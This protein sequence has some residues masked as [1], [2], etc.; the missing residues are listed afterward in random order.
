MLHLLERVPTDESV[1]TASHGPSFAEVIQQ[2]QEQQQ[3]QDAPP[4]VE[5]RYIPKEFDQTRSN[6]HGVVYYTEGVAGRYPEAI[7]FTGKARK[8]AWYYSFSGKTGLERMHAH[9]DSYLKGLEAHFAE[10]EKY[11]AA[12]AAVVAS[13]FFKVG[14]IVSNSWGWE[15]TNVDW[16]QV[17]GVTKKFVD[18]R[19]IAGKLTEYT[20]AMA[21][22]SIPIPGKFTSE[23]ITRH[24]IYPSGDSC[25]VNFKH[26]SGSKWDGKPEYC[27]WYG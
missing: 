3:Q 1:T 22:Y 24:G 11:K 8:S 4:A 2:W 27:S 9:I 26:G 17:V 14:D 16:Y 23:E 7:A 5:G 19:P 10:K 20:Q 25:G 12:R 13:D 21:G 6:K 15:Q 18:L